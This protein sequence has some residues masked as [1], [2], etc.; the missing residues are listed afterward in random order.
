[1]LRTRQPL[2]R[3]R[4]S[5]LLLWATIAVA[6]LALVLPFTGALATVFGFVPLSA[7][8]LV[9]TIAIVVAPLA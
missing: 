1:M 7:A 8:V 9:A 3:S 6:L 5:A 4:P 2:Y